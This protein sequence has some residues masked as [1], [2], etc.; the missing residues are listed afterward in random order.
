M[1]DESEAQPQGSA[2]AETAAPAPLPAPTARKSAGGVW[3]GVFGGLLGGVAVSALAVGGLVVAWPQLQSHLLGSSDEAQ[4]LASLDQ[5]LAQL[6]QRVA[7]LE[8][9]HAAAAPAAAVDPQLSQRIAALEAGVADPRLPALAQKVEQSTADIDALRKAMPPE[10]L[11]L[12]LADRAEAA[13][14]IAR[15]IASRHES[16]QALLLVVGQL[17][18]AVDRGDAYEVELHAARR[19]APADAAAA[20]DQLAPTAT[21]GVTRRQALVEAFPKL[22]SQV[23]N[24]AVAPAEGSL[25]QRALNKLA[26]LITLRRTD[27]SGDDAAS[28][29]SR[30]EMAVKQDDLDKAV[31]ELSALQGPAA[32]TAAP[33]VKAASAR[34]AVDRALS[35]LAATAVAE[36]AK[37]GG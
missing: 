29:V 32:E 12:R 3:R 21:S 36:T 22:A 8:G 6:T 30:A 34:L 35:Q 19:V 26:G 15:E 5:A 2:A 10:G 25:W 28:V 23:V 14:K 24:A 16:A 37:S 17:R 31:S 1:T 4:H 18:E 13:E 33:W 20:L 7:A 9:S 27:G 11:L